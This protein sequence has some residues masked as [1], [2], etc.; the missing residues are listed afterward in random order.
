MTGLR[1]G[2]YEVLSTIGRGAVGIVYKA[3]D[4]NIDRIVAIKALKS[5][6][7]GDNSPENVELQRFYQEA[8]AAGK[9]KHPNIVTIY[10]V[11]CTDLG[12]P[13]IV[14]EYIEGQTLREAIESFGRC[15]PLGALYYLSQIGSAIDYAH[16]QGVL[17]RDINPGNILLDKDQRP[18]LVDFS[19]AKL[20]DISLTPTGGLVGSPGYMAPELIKGESPGESSD[21]FSLA[22]VAFELLTGSLPFPGDDIIRTVYTVVNDPPITFRQLGVSLPEGIEQIIAKGLSKER[23]ERYSCAAEFVN[24]LRAAIDS[25]FKESS[26]SSM[27]ETQRLKAFS[28]A[29]KINSPKKGEEQSVKA[30]QMVDPMED[31]MTRDIHAEKYQEEEFD[32]GFREDSEQRKFSKPLISKQQR[33][34]IKPV[35]VAL[36]LLLLALCSIFIYQKFR[37][38]NQTTSLQNVDSLL[39]LNLT[40]VELL[41]R[42]SANELKDIMLSKNTPPAQLKA[43]VVEAA[44]RD[45]DVLNALILKLAEHPDELIRAEVFK[46]LAVKKMQKL[47]GARQVLLKGLNDSDYLVRGYAVGAVAESGDKT[48]LDNLLALKKTETRPIVLQ[49]I[50]ESIGKLSR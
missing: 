20:C 43:V 28:P 3:R 33:V 48:Y 30:S 9:L 12:M 5:I 32:W 8:Q 26:S 44:T 38:S 47:P 19:L 15:E 42:L 18:Y 2:K 45:S 17:H 11:G 35:S 21:I 13:Y 4:P 41:K 16:S 14:M 46:A 31:L 40:D 49:I 7:L 23:S 27:D 36:L 24:K 34:F 1:I 25:N 29:N 10:D 39:L 50:E 22:V 37:V 6:F